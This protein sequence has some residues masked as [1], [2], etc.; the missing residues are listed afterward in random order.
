MN[1]LLTFLFNSACL[2]THDLETIMQLEQWGEFYSIVAC[3]HFVIFM[4]IS[5]NTFDFSFAKLAVKNTSEKQTMLMGVWA[6]PSFYFA[7]V[8]L[9]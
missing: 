3:F 6:M 2:V 4:L 5:K 7:F 1:I 8:I 9:M